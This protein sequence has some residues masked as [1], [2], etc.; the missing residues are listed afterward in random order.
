MEV[1]LSS[2][3]NICLVHQYI[4]VLV[5]DVLLGPRAFI[6]LNLVNRYSFLSPC[7]PPS[8]SF[9]HTNAAVLAAVTANSPLSLPSY[10]TPDISFFPP[11]L[12]SPLASNKPFFCFHFILKLYILSAV[13]FVIPSHRVTLRDR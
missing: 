3:S 8:S 2:S 9:R 12:Y 6:S 5:F 13:P 1:Y 7:L 11:L 10:N 4:A